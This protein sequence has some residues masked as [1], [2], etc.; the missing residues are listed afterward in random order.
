MSPFFTLVEIV[1]LH[2]EFDIIHIHLD[3]VEFFSRETLLNAHD[4]N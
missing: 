2:F 3:I 1:Q 4:I